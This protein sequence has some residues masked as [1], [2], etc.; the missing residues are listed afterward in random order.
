MRSGGAFISIPLTLLQWCFHGPVDPNMIVNNVCIAHAI[1]DADRL[2]SEDD[3]TTTRVAA[4]VSTAFYAST[5][6]TMAIAPLVP[7]LHLGYSTLKPY[8]APVKP[9]LVSAIWTLAIYYVPLLRMHKGLWGDVLTPPR[10]LSIASLSHA[11]DVADIEDDEQE[12]LMTPAVTMGERE[13]FV[14]AFVL[15]LSSHLLPCP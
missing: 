15:A 4:L 5:P 10:F 2:T 13:G 8:I 11:L 12:G 3:P 7:T 6:E 14:F 1:Y 9:F